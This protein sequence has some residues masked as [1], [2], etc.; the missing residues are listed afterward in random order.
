M[1]AFEKVNNWAEEHPME[2]A[3]TDPVLYKELHDALSYPQVDKCPFCKKCPCPHWNGLGWV[4]PK[5]G[6]N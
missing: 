5:F 1:N 2:T 6:G 4:N 3:L